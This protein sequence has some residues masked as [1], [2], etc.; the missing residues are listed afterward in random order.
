M[1][2]EPGNTALTD[3]DT[4]A[5]PPEATPPVDP[6]GQVPPTGQEPQAPTE[7]P[8]QETPPPETPPTNAEGNSPPERVVPGVD[9]YKFAEG[10]PSDFGKFASDLDMTQEQADGVL[11]AHQSLKTAEMQMVRQ[12][13][14]AHIKN[15]GEKADY[16]MNLA[17]RAMKQNDP[18]GSLAKLFNATGYGNHPAVL[19]FFLQLGQ[20]LK[21]GGF[22]KSELNA[23]GEKSRAQKMFPNM[24]SESL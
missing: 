9:G 15:W 7:T 24:K 17:K 13:G 2:D 18:D 16:N 4:A 21:E 1:T 3:T 14:E 12:A 23:P 8:P 20:G 5:A 10:V 6:Q 19:D 11:N 22:L